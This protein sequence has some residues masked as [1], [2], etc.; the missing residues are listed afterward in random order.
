MARVVSRRGVRVG[1]FLLPP[2]TPVWVHPFSMHRSSRL[3]GESA[4]RWEEGEGE[5]GAKTRM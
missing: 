4:G 1:G 2:G 5:G 3:W